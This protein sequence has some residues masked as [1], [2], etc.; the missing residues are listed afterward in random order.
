MAEVP[1]TKQLEASIDNIEAIDSKNPMETAEKAD[2]ME[3]AAEVTAAEVAAAA[4]KQ[5]QPHPQLYTQLPING[6]DIPI[7]NKI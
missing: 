7:L 1:P 5:P 6:I 2:P 3:T 4:G